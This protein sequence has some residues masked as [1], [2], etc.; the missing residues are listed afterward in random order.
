MSCSP[1]DLR[2][3]FFG[4]LPEQDRRQADLH[5]KGCVS[6]RE[7]LE[8]LRSTQAV[9]LT[10]P[11]EE[12]P[13]RIAFVSDRVYEPSAVRRW[14]HAFWGSAP[15]LGFAS[16]AM[17]SMA[18]LVHARYQPA[19]AAPAPAPT[20]DIARIQ[21]D[22]SRQVNEAVAEAV[23]ASDARHEQRSAQLLTAAA[24]RFEMQ[25][26]AERQMVSQNFDIMAKYGA[27]DYR[28]AMFRDDTQ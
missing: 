22:V 10:A 9:L 28:A 27:R 7:E 19:P 17:L 14:W 13:Q 23:A 20:V 2:D 8:A 11:D 25:L 15:R 5:V 6:C 12:I 26:R 3:Y 21:A 24:K 18:I 1:F 4:E 16:A